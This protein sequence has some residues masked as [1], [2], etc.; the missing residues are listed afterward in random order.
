MFTILDK[1]QQNNIQHTNPIALYLSY[2][3]AKWYSTPDSSVLF[4]FLNFKE[5][6]IDSNMNK[7]SI[8]PALMLQV[9]GSDQAYSSGIFF[10]PGVKDLFLKLQEN[11][12]QMQGLS[13][14]MKQT[15]AHL[16]IFTLPQ[17]CPHNHVWLTIWNWSNAALPYALMNNLS[18]NGRMIP[19]FFLNN[20]LFSRKP[21]NTVEMIKRKPNTSE[22]I[23]EGKRGAG[24]HGGGGRRWVLGDAG[25]GRVR[26]RR[27]SRPSER[28]IMR[29]KWLF[30]SWECRANLSLAP[31]NP[32]T[33]RKCFADY[34]LAPARSVRCVLSVVC[35]CLCSSRHQLS[36]ALLQTNCF[37][38]PVIAHVVCSLI[39]TEIH[40]SSVSFHVPILPCR[41]EHT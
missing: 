5:N 10:F 28:W 27:P 26:R 38:S 14:D 16:I 2:F 7:T 1:Y 41:I 4:I 13:G 8:L 31:G 12:L 37:L 9:P 25:V 24:G 3:V 18:W 36:Q 19:C 40:C 34:C 11:I 35:V 17:N 33:C 15:W 22:W 32:P 6:P 21:G 30:L 20:S 29:F 23:E 39:V